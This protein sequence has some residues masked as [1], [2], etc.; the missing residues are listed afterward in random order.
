VAAEGI[1]SVS[2][3]RGEAFF[4]TSHQGGT[5]SDCPV[6]GVWRVAR[7]AP[8][9]IVAV[10]S[11][12]DRLVELD[13]VTG[14]VGAVLATWDAAARVPVGAGVVAIGPGASPAIRPD[15]AVLAFAADRGA[16]SGSSACA[17]DVVVLDLA[18]GA[19]RVLAAARESGADGR[20]IVR[21]EV[22]GLRWR[23]AP[24]A[25]AA[26]S[27]SGSGPGSERASGP[28]VL[29]V[30]RSYEG[31]WTGLVDLSRAV[32]LEDATPL[33]TGSAADEWA[34]SDA[35]WLGDG[36]VVVASWCCYPEHVQRGRLAVVDADGEVVPLT[37]RGERASGLAVSPA[38]ADLAYV[39]SPVTGSGSVAAPEIVVRRG[40]GAP[41]VLAQGYVALDW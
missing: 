4:A 41:S 16:A 9:A 37:E 40:L 33:L 11:G 34:P 32:S 23:P 22:R 2:V 26:G 7:K 25:A 30:T 1:V 38:G 20:A 19:E 24:P 13:P 17:P 27:G 21:D 35:D 5:S 12:R 14:A 36:R 28:D 31:D 8:E 39:R 18:T 3:S 15:G 29:A 10:G 6:T